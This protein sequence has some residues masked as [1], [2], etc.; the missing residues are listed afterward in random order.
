MHELSL[1]VGI[2]DI[3]REQAMQAGAVR[4]NRVEIEVG[5]LAGVLTESL[6]FCWDSVRREEPLLATAELVIHTVAGA[7]R[8]PACGLLAPMATWPAPC[9][10]CGRA[11]LEALQGRELRVR[12]LN[13]D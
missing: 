13:I 5:E 12:S 9:P 10:G 6:A 2:G 1:A 3:A 7:G 4:V 11:T 8:C